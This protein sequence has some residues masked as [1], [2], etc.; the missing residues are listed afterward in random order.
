MRLICV[1]VLLIVFSISFILSFLLSRSRF[2]AIS[3][4]SS[5]LSLLHVE[6]YARICSLLRFFGFHNWSKGIRYFSLVQN[7][8]LLVVWG[9][10]VFLRILCNPP[11][12]VFQKC[13]LATIVQILCAREEGMDCR[14]LFR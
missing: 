8:C 3:V 9:N 6:M 12:W 5:E 4:N 7:L 13:L 2:L 14:Q 10:F 1:L 11:R